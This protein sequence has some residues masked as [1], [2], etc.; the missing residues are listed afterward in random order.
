MFLKKDIFQLFLNMKNKRVLITGTTSGIGKSLAKKYKDNGFDVITVNKKD[1]LKELDLKYISFNIDITSKKEIDNL[2]LELKEQELFPDIFIFNAG[3]NK[4]DFE[5][6]FEIEIFKDILNINFFSIVNFCLILKRENYTNKTL[7]FISSFSTIF[8]NPN[9]NGY[10]VSKL[11]LNNFF[12]KNKIIDR[13]NNYKIISLGPVNTKIKRYIECEKTINKFF[14]RLLS[15]DL[16]KVTNKI[17]KFSLSKKS[18]LQYPFKI[19][20]FY[21]FCKIFFTFLKMLKFKNN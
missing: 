13:K 18:S 4:I 3:I 5:K 6:K 1:S 19:F 20:L 12:K 15:T 16:I 8:P 11:L 2:F 10:F 21:Y 17:Y 14:F 7:I 9:N